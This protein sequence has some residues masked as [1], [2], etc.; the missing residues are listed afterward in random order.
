MTA[1]SAHW[2][3]MIARE[4]CLSLAVCTSVT[5]PRTEPAPV[6]LSDDK[7]LG[8][9]VEDTASMV[10]VSNDLGMSSTVHSMTET[11]PLGVGLDV[12]FLPFLIPSEIS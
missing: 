8:F 9:T 10:L 4:L 2:H 1:T 6:P 7:K 11:L 5:M 12:L 3:D